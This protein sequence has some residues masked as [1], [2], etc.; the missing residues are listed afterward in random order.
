[1]AY[2]YQTGGSMAWLVGLGNLDRVRAIAAVDAAPPARTKLPENDPVNRLALLIGAAEK[3]AIAPQLKA[4]L[5]RLEAA[6]FPITRVSLGDQPR[7]LSA[8]E[9]EQLGRWIDALDRI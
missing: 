3:S 7:D 9:L 6:R 8:A 1:V 5:T 4:V 2:G